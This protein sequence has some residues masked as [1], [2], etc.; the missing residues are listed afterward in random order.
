MSKTV[1][2][3]GALAPNGKAIAQLFAQKGYAVVLQDE[4]SEGAAKMAKELN[5]KAVKG[6]TLTDNGAKSTAEKAKTAG[7]NRTIDTMPDG[8]R[9]EPSMILLPTIFARLFAA[10]SFPPCALPRQYLP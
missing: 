2:I 1:L 7:G 4:D 9:R 5:V 6:T 10:M 3:T 8:I